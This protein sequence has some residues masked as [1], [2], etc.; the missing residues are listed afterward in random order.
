MKFSER[1][2]RRKIFQKLKHTEYKK[3]KFEK[4][5]RLIEFDVRAVYAALLLL[6]AERHRAVPFSALCVYLRSQMSRFSEIIAVVVV[7]FFIH[8]SLLANF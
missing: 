7:Q 3:K 8:L 5:R 1:V 2:M 6:S 4:H